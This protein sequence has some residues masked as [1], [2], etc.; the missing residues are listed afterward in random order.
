LKQFSRRRRKDWA[1]AWELSPSIS[2]LI[3]I[4]NVFTLLYQASNLNFGQRFQPKNHVKKT[5]RDVAAGTPVR[6][7][8]RHSGTSSRVS[9]TAQHLA[10]T[11]PEINDIPM[12]RWCAGRARHRQPVRAAH[13]AF[14]GLHTDWNVLTDNIVGNIIRRWRR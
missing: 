13:D 3:S 14:R 8:S 7:H 11:V 4:K 10:A 2:H 1:A 9:S 6:H 12:T 5:N